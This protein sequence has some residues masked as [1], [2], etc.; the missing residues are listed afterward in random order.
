M[1]VAKAALEAVVALPGA[2]PRPARRAREPRLRRARSGRSPRAG[3]PASSSSPTRG[4]EQ[5]PLGWDTDDPAPVADAVVLPALATS[6]AAITGE[7]LHVDGG[8]HAMGAPLELEAAERPLR[9]ARAS[10][11]RG[12]GRP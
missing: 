9:P 2:R 10:P 1:G 3:S 5:A 6:R 4:S 7:I 8:F 11:D 12:G